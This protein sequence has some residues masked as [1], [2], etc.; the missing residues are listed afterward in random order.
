MP[1][2]SNFKA[3]PGIYKYIP[4]YPSTYVFN[5]FP[6]DDLLRELVF[7]NTFE[8]LNL[9]IA[10]PMEDAGVIKLYEPSPT[11]WPYVADIQNMMGRAPL[12][13][14]FLAGNSIPTIPHIFSK[15]K[16]SGFPYGCADAAATEGRR[17]SN[18]YEVNPWL[19]QFGRGKPRLGGQT[20]KETS[21][22]K[23]AVSN[24]RHK[25]AAETVRHRK[26]APA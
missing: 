24:A 19:W 21:E 6:P 22:R 12:M 7:F 5:H 23:D 20:I 9:P 2:N 15:C 26:A 4:V 13:P 1:K 11:P 10:G 18:V 14:L 16:D 17:S 3:G 8:E 25:R